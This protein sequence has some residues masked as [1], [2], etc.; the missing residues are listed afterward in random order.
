MPDLPETLEAERASHYARLGT[1]DEERI[2]TL[3][4]IVPWPAGGGRWAIIRDGATTFVASDG[5]SDPRDGEGD[6]PGF[7][8]EV[9]MATSAPIEDPRSS[10][11]FAAVAEVSNLIAD[12]AF[13]EDL[14]PLLDELGTVSLSLTNV[15]DVPDDYVAE[16]GTIGALIGVRAGAIPAAIGTRGA[17]LLVVRLLLASEL[18]EILDEGDEARARIA[19]ALE[20][21]AAPHLEP[22]KREGQPTRAAAPPPP[23]L[24]ERRREMDPPVGPASELLLVSG[25]SKKVTEEDLRQVFATIGEVRAVKLGMMNRV[26]MATAERGQKAVAALHGRCVRGQPI[27][28]AYMHRRR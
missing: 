6:N 3:M 2:A 26:E 27:Q 5:L 16:D 28:L 13:G 21:G 4:P 10:W 22:L 20:A 24:A 19:A 11:L 1:L 7:G 18:A 23:L 8:V 14:R 12:F 25:L 17:R 15:R 9:I